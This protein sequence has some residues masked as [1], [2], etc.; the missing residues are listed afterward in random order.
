[1]I[2]ELDELLLQ[3][4]SNGANYNAVA[5]WAFGSCTEDCMQA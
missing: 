1:M 4:D 2:N 3:G 5:K